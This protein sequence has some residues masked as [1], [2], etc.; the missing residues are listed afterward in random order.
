MKPAFFG[1]SKKGSEGERNIKKPGY[2]AAFVIE[3]KCEE[4]RHIVTLQQKIVFYILKIP[5]LVHNV[6]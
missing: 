4:T 2:C 3:H 5:Y 1:S 6:I